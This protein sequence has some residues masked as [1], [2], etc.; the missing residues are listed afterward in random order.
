MTQT[1]F[2]ATDTPRCPGSSGEDFEL[3][4]LAAESTGDVRRRALLHQ[5]MV[6]LA[7]PL[8][9][10]IA[11][12]YMGRGVETDDL[13]QVARIGLVKAVRRYQPSKGSTFAAFATPTISGELKRWFRD[14]G[15]S[16][17]PPRRIQELRHLM[18]SEEEQLQGVLS[19]PP[20][21]DELCAAMEVDRSALAEVRLCTMAYRAVSLDAPAGPNTALADKVLTAACP[22]DEWDTWDALGRAMA[23]LTERQRRI[24][25]LRFGQDLTQSQIAERIG[26]SQMQVSR[27]L[28]SIL[29]QLRAELEQTLVDGRTLAG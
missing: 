9:D 11:R 22:M 21:E 10:N 19:R 3:L 28:R 13:V 4:A 26:V 12:R 14:H 17:R 6:V 27:L 18:A 5:E 24:V 16:V 25:E 23:A 8:A 1:A 29:E 2:P 20:T 15:W 7:L